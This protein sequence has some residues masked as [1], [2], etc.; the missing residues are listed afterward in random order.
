[1][2]EQA[3]LQ[4][5][6]L[7]IIPPEPIFSEIHQL[8]VYVKEK[9]NTKAALNSPP[10]ITL[11]MPFMW[12]EHKEAI[13]IEKL[14]AFGQLQTPFEIKLNNFNAFAPRV[15]Y[16]DVVPNNHLV[17]LQKHLERF[18]KI[19]FQLF[20]AN[21]LDQPFHPHLTLAFRDLKKGIFD[22]AWQ[23]FSNKQYSA[24]WQVESIFIL[25]HNGSIWEKYKQVGLKKTIH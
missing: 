11:H 23:E 1:M 10:H 21:R 12:K 18:C 5:Y 22:L 2:K 25:K 13:L 7:A 19:N 20:N 4:R 17:I 15:I 9:Y 24:T 14:E 6:F 16:A 3:I 8:K